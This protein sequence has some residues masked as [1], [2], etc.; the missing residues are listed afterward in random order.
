MESSVVV[1]PVDG[2]I[3]NLSRPREILFFVFFFAFVGLR[4]PQSNVFNQ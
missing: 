2:N 1:W 4:K 3:K